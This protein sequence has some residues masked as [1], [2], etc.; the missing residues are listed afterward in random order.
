VI[1][2]KKVELKERIHTVWYSSYCGADQIEKNV[3]DRKLIAHGGKMCTNYLLENLK[4]G[5]SFNKICCGGL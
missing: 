5:D 2:P 3:L 4:N 1:G